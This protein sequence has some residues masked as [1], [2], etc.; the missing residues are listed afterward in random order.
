M[1]RLI[2]FLRAIN[3]GGHTVTMD[4][5]RGIFDALGFTN[6]E[7]FIASGN[8][9]FSSRSAGKPALVG[10]IENRLHTELG[11]EVKTFLR[12]QKEVAAITRYRPFPESQIRSAGAF[13]VGF[14]A[15]PL[16]AAATRA[17]G[18]LKTDIDDFH[19][20]GRE[21]YWLCKRKQSDSTFSNAVFER[22]VKVPV[23]FRGMQTMSRLAARYALL[24]SDAVNPIA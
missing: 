19:V 3:V 16:G 14:L 12:T 2:A 21:L 7:T 11:F 6:V 1:T 18:A 23:T 13:S 4:N 22:R 24:G 5:L 17:L 8:V 9:L 15:A 10:R 20:H